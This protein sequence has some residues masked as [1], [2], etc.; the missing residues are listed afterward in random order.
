L[1]KQQKRLTIEY[2]VY[3]STLFISYA[4]NYLPI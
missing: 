4:Q 1:T 2:A 3:L